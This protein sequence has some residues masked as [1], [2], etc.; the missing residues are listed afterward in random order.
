MPM[1]TRL[2]W[3][4]EPCLAVELYRMIGIVAGL[5]EGTLPTH[6]SPFPLTGA[7]GFIRKFS[8]LPTELE[9]FTPVVP[10]HCWVPALVL[11][12]SEDAVAVGTGLPV[13]WGSCTS[14][15][16]PYI[17]QSESPHLLGSIVVG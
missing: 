1:V 3:E 12:Q 10:L 15:F 9:L 4:L 13:G 7:L 6:P 2:N 14:S 8:A 11:S 16:H 5:H 17:N